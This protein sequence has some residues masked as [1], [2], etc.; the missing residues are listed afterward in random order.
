[1]HYDTGVSKRGEERMLR[2]AR[3]HQRREMDPMSGR[4][5]AGAERAD[6]L[7]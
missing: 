1:M 5:L 4:T 7:F 6:D 3:L 2:L